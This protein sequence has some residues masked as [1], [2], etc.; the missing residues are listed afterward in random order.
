MPE[1]FDQ[2]NT[3]EEVTTPVAKVLDD[4]S[5][6]VGD[7][8]YQPDA[9]AKKLSH[10][11]AHIATLETENAEHVT[12]ATQLMDRLDRLEDKV[13]TTDD[14]GNLID[15]L[16]DQSDQQNEPEVKETTTPISKEELVEAA[17]DSIE[18]D[19]IKAQQEQNLNDAVSRAKTVYGEDFGPTIDKMGS[20][21]DMS[22][23]EV[24]DL[25]R[26]NPAAWRRLFLPADAVTAPDTTQSSVIVEDAPRVEPPRK[27]YL[28]LRSSKLQREEFQRRMKEKLAAIGT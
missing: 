15:T 17:K 9:L 6:V 14:L 26:N 4:G 1:S 8:V 22:V 25:A 13:K 27:S 10:Q 24:V 12:N 28:K 11:E 23:A 3:T 2:T 5:I 18:A 16:K 21:L 19:R 7:K 20:D